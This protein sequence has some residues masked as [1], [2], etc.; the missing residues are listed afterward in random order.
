MTDKLDISAKNKNF[1][2][3]RL[4]ST[5]LRVLALSCLVV[6]VWMPLERESGRDVFFLLDVSA[7]VRRH[8]TQE[9]EN[10]PRWYSSVL[11]SLNSQDRAALIAFGSR[12][13]LLICLSSPSEFSELQLPALSQYSNLPSGEKS[14]FEMALRLIFGLTELKRETEIWVWSDFLETAGDFTALAPEIEK[15]SIRLN[16][17]PFPQ[18]IR[19]DSRIVNVEL[20]TEIQVAAE[21][22]ARINLEGDFQKTSKGNLKFSLRRDS[23]SIELP[24]LEIELAAREIRSFT[25][26]FALPREGLYEFQ[27][28]WNPEPFDPISENNRTSTWIR[29]GEFLRVGW[30]GVANN[31]LTKLRRL[32]GMEMQIIEPENLQSPLGGL[33]ACFLINPNLEGGELPQQEIEQFLHRGGILFLSCSAQSIPLQQSTNNKQISNLLPFRWD[34]APQDQES[35]LLLLDRSG[36]MS[37]GK[38]ELALRAARS[39]SLQIPVANELALAFFGEKLETPQIW[40]SVGESAPRSIE[41][42]PTEGARGG[43]AVASSLEAALTWLDAQRKTNQRQRIFLLSDG[44]EESRE[45]KENWAKEFGERLASKNIE[46]I[47]FAVGDDAD[48][49]SLR[50]L[51]QNESNGKV[52]LAGSLNNLESLFLEHSR[53]HFLEPGP[54]KVGKNKSN[55]LSFLQ[56]SAPDLQSRWKLA[57]NADSESLYENQNGKPVLAWKR[58]GQGAVMALA[59]PLNAGWENESSIWESLLRSLVKRKKEET[60]SSTKTWN[61][62]RGEGRSLAPFFLNSSIEPKHFVWSFDRSLLLLAALVLFF[63]SWFPKKF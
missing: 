46:L 5:L 13:E 21:G 26:S 25:T 44:R 39:L 47:A 20:P 49:G 58:V 41:F 50:A 29:C 32:P 56:E 9:L 52:L 57:L 40:K 23:Q 36:S 2:S 6:A 17:L 48:L 53:S 62:Y 12:P 61:E 54:Q 35:I 55:S 7:S 10:L 63:F 60:R 3:R 30:F 4:I 18:E 45:K 22:V 14:N 28:I 38:L 33:D 8:Y 1:Q 16:R 24:S 11:N 37:G 42:I 19:R 51:T 34:L 15:R 59:S 31:L 43:T 27:A